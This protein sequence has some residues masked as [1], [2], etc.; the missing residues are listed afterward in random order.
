MTNPVPA[1]DPAAPDWSIQRWTERVAGRQWPR[2]DQHLLTVGPA[3]P[4]IFTTS[5]ALQ[6]VHR[7]DLSLFVIFEEASLR[8]SGSLTRRAPDLDSLNFAAQQTIDEARHH[9]QF[10]RRLDL[11]RALVGQAPGG[12]SEEIRIPPLRT[13]LDHCYEVADGGSYT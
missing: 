6:E 10:R 9:E 2:E 13:F 1:V 4:E 12:V 7:L 3:L 8:V 11:S 5:R